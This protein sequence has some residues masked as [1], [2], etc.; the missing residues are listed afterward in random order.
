LGLPIGGDFGWHSDKAMPI[1][2]IKPLQSEILPN[3]HATGGALALV[4]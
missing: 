1:V 3:A 4:D 2:I